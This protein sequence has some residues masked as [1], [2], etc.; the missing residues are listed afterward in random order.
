[1]SDELEILPCPFCSSPGEMN[2]GCFGERYVT[3][4]KGNCGAGLG[5]GIWFKEEETAIEIWNTRTYIPEV[6]NVKLV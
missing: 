1:M 2:I 6:I 5:G 4:S 3:C